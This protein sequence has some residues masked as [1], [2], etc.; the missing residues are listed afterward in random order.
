MA[1]TGTVE[2]FDGRHKTV[3]RALD[4]CDTRKLADPG[5]EGMRTEGQKKCPQTGQQTRSTQIQLVLPG[6]TKARDA[7]DTELAGFETI[8]LEMLIFRQWP[9][10]V[11]R[12]EGL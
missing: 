9:R 3:R 4:C 11:K 1:A 12:P 5:L 8:K 7:I 2:K 10:A 6:V